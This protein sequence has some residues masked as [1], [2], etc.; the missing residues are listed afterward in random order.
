MTKKRF[1]PLQ[2]KILLF[3]LI[4]IIIPIIILGII[5]F[6]KSSQ[7]LQEKISL[8]N[9]NTVEQIGNNIDFIV[10]NVQDIS[11]YLIQNGD[12]RSYL[13]LRGNESPDVIL[14]K[15]LKIENDLLELISPKVFINSIYIK[16]FNN[17][18]VNTDDD[19]ANYISQ[20]NASKSLALK[21]G[22][23]WYLDR[24]YDYNNRPSGVFSMVRS[25]YDINNITRKMAIMKINIDENAFYDIYKDKVIG[26]GDEF[27]LL[28]NNGTVISATSKGKTGQNFD[29]KIFGRNSLNLNEGY[30]K[31]NTRGTVFLVTYYKIRSNGWTIINMVPLKQLLKENT[32]NQQ[33]VFWAMIFSFAVCILIVIFFSGKALVRLKRLCK[34]MEKIEHE[35]FGVY[36]EPK[37]NDE[38]TLLYRSFNNMS[39]KLKELIHKVYTVQIKQK[40]A[41]LKALQAQ[42]NPHFLFNTLDNIYWMGRMESAF[43]TSKMVEALSKL[44][45]L[46]LNSGKEITTVRTE[47]EHVR[48]YIIIQQVRF[49]DEI[50]F[51]LDIDD[52]VLDCLTLKLV[53]QPLIENSIAH[54]IKNMGK[55]GIINVTVKQN[56]MKLIFI[57]QDN[58]CGI[59]LEEI[60]RLLGDTGDGN[61]GFAVKNV[62]DRIKLYFGENYGLEFVKGECGTTVIVSQPY[63]KEETRHDQDIAN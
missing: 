28:D 31:I 38:I 9:M 54:G 43:E 2:F 5:S 52:E 15:K 13:N 30:F 40:E 37:G 29:Y 55:D 49:K 45:R 17:L 7:V 35:D 50:K 60:N 42:I 53:L 48:N 24:V 10:Q 32:E 59:D 3:S 19:T 56:G 44:F 61:R 27:Y 26:Q 62:N 46:S 16:G 4:V 36:V 6:K 12:L 63:F 18:E 58:G 34:L 20:Q 51:S 22:P 33:E 14:Q 21:G 8:S 39:S 25:I 23:M 11:L 47:I 57:V 41:E 1:F